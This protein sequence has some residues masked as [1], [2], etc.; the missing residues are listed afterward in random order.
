V[1]FDP[2]LLA[3]APLLRADVDEGRHLAAVRT[4]AAQT[5]GGP[6]RDEH[7]NVAHQLA[8]L[9]VTVMASAGCST[10]CRWL[11]DMLRLS[12]TLSGF[13]M[14]RLSAT[15]WPSSV[16]AF[17]N[18]GVTAFRNG[19]LFSKS[20]AILVERLAG[21]ARELPRWQ[22]SPPSAARLPSS[23]SR[24]CGVRPFAVEA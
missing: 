11:L 6:T 14:L 18:V 3:V 19:V 12:A 24:Q 7:D 9:V 15:L 5:S 4:P 20:G 16:T 23:V 22:I 10:P 21:P 2:L 1:P 13:A 8:L 17:R